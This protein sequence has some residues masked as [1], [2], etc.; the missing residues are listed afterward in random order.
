MAKAEKKNTVEVEFTPEQKSFQAH[1]QSLTTKINQ[2]LF[3]IDELQP[4]LNMYK[5]ALTESMKGQTD[6]VKEESNNDNS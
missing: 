2:H 3:E 4:S 5:Q 1:I 6:K